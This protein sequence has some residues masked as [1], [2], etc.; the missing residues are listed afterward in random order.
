MLVTFLLLFPSLETGREND[1]GDRGEVRG[2]G[3]GFS[4]WSVTWTFL[5][6]Q[7]FCF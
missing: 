5:R 3:G 1:G 6:S 7:S 2:A 4:V